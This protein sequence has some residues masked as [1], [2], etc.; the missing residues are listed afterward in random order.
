M[1]LGTLLQKW[2]SGRSYK[3]QDSLRDENTSDAIGCLAE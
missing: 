3:V 2:L 1:S